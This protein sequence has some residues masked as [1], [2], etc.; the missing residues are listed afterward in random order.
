M[1]LLKS[2]IFW[3]IVCTITIIIIGL[4][5]L[6]RFLEGS[7]T[8]LYWCQQAVLEDFYQ[9]YGDHET[10]IQSTKINNTNSEIPRGYAEDIYLITI[11]YTEDEYYITHKV[12]EAKYYVIISFKEN[13]TKFIHKQDIY[14]LDYAKVENENG[15]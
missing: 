6:F 11:V 12:K 13:R 15:G 8:P 10:L 5:N 2:Y 14:D 1:K 7:A 4:I 3:I 9:E